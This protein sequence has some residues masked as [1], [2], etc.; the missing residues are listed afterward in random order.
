MKRELV[1]LI[2]SLEARA[3]LQRQSRGS[4]RNEVL[5][6]LEAE[7]HLETWREQLTSE[8]TADELVAA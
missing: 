3:R 2:E 1:K 7:E 4:T 5:A 8:I 6:A